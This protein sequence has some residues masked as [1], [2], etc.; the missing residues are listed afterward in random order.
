MFFRSREK[1]LES[2]GG[3]PNALDSEEK[4]SS[5]TTSGKEPEELINQGATNLKH[6]VRVL[7]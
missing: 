7:G 3:D 5:Q 6:S 1:F 2:S 4:S